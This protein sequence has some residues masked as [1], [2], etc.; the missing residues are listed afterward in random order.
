M[1]LVSKVLTEVQEG[2]GMDR[3]IDK[4]HPEGLE[5]ADAITTSR[6]DQ[7]RRAIIHKSAPSN[8]AQI[9]PEDAT[10]MVRADKRGCPLLCAVDYGV[11]GPRG[12]MGRDP[13][14]V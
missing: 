3:A 1:V 14:P 10:P 4:L 11:F 13:E 9:G 7:K 12:S 5:D 8:A 2:G 6:A